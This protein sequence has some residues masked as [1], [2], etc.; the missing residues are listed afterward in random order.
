MANGPENKDPDSAADEKRVYIIQDST[1]KALNLNN[2]TQEWSYDFDD[3][4]NYTKPVLYDNLVLFETYGGYLCALNA[5][6]GNLLWKTRISVSTR[7]SWRAS[8]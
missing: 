5:D 2:G 8:R 7:K 3:V 1:V 6:N 4:G